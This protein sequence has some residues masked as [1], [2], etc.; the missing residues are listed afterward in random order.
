MFRKLVA[1]FIIAACVLGA[2]HAAAV[3]TTA[4]SLQADVATPLCTA[5]RGE[6][7]KPESVT[8]RARPYVRRIDKGK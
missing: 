6:D 2:G 3:G 4:R 5:P 7:A 8:Q 1:S